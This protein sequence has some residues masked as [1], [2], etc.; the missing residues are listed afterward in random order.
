MSGGAQC[1]IVSGL[2]ALAASALLLS[3]LIAPARGSVVWHVNAT[4][5]DDAAS[6]RSAEAPF[7]TIQKAA[8]VVA[9]GDVV[10]VHPGIYFEHVQLRKTGTTE[11]PIIFQADRVEANR[12]VITGADQAIRQGKV[13]WQLEDSSL[14]L[15]SAPLDHAPARVLYDG[16][17]LLPYPTLRS[18]KD[19]RLGDGYP[20]PE[21]GFTTES[22]RLYVR[23]HA[24]GTYGPIDPSQ[25][26]MRVSPPKGRGNAGII[27]SRPTDYGFGVLATGPAHVTLDGFTFETPGAAGVFVAG[28]DVIVRNCWFLGCHSGVAGLENSPDPAKT[29]NNVTI[30]F[31]D[32]THFPAFADMKE[33]I[34]LHANDPWRGDRKKFF[35]KVYWWHRKGGL[36]AKGYTYEV[37]IASNIGSDWV[38]RNNRMVDGFE[39]LSAWAVRWSRNLQ[40][41]QNHLERLVDNAIEAEDHA[42]NLRFHDNVVIDVFEPFSWQPLGG[43]PWPGPIYIYRNVVWNTPENGGLWGEAGWTPGIWKLGAQEDNWT[44]KDVQ[45][46]PDEPVRPPGD[47]FLAFNNTVILTDHNILTRV[48][49]AKRLFE[50]FAIFNNVVAA[51]DFNQAGASSGAGIAFSHNV[52]VMPITSES[53]E[54]AAAFARDGKLVENLSEVGTFE[55]ESGRLALSPESP[56]R[57]MRRPGSPADALPDAGAVAFGAAWAPPICG[58]QK[59]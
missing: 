17:D 26:S 33:V 41:Y 30:E 49:S 45:I 55:P 52:A 46:P 36:L 10:V 23:L 37:G 53:A 44:R 9:A 24:G 31:C 11:K 20:G 28:G 4:D 18:L 43:L 15:Y 39:F 8:D 58:P 2:L 48:Q 56:A 42:F 29:T 7:K 6:G 38:I 40:I 59:R 34:R 57:A 12:V 25:H 32:M 54:G 27:V 21:H 50:N 5:G 51:K 16:V 1:R 22:G 35:Q 19:F 3:G 13:A 14:Q 47:G